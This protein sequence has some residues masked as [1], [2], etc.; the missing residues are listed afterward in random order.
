MPSVSGKALKVLVVGI[1][2]GSVACASESPAGSTGWEMV[3]PSGTLGA[4][5][6]HVKFSTSAGAIVTDTVLHAQMHI[7]APIVL[8]SEDR[9][10]LSRLGPILSGRSESQPF[11]TATV[12]VHGTLILVSVEERSSQGRVTKINFKSSVS[13]VTYT[14]PTA[15]TGHVLVDAAAAGVSDGFHADM[16]FGGSTGASETS[17]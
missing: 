12:Q 1:C 9:L 3:N 6:I 5:D 2:M 11:D 16:V 14:L 13:S 8:T 15:P 7:D 10:N 4:G 17:A